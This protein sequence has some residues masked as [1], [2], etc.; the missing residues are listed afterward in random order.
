MIITSNNNNNTVKLA[1]VEL[2]EA[3]NNLD[4]IPF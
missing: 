2:R 3:K 1:K 4:R